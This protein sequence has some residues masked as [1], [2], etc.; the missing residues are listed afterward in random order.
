MHAILYL[1]II[2]ALR[3]PLAAFFCFA[4]LAAA[5]SALDVSLSLLEERI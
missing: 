5:A 4:A 3:S 2:Y 1:I